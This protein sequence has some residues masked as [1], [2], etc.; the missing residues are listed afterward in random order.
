MTPRALVIG[1]LGTAAA[2]L[3]IAVGVSR[4]Q[5][6]FNMGGGTFAAPVTS[7]RDMPFRQVV[8]QQYDYSC[9]SAALATLLRHHYGRNVTEASI[10]Q[11]MFAVGDQDKIRRVG[12]SLLDMK[13]HLAALGLKSDGYR[14]TL[15]DLALAKAPAIA[16]IKVGDYRHFVVIKGVRDGKVMVGDPNQGLKLY[17]LAEFGRVWNGVVFVIHPDGGQPAF[18][19]RDEWASLAYGPMDRLDD[20]SLAAF[21]RA[22]PPI[23]QVMASRETGVSR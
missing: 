1:L 11:A 17:S 18:N 19:R 14:Q 23:Y 22:L 10:F 6:M 16:L 4:A 21:T 12:F 2:S 20:R 5:P 8:R 9:G 15:Q 7:L 3:S 13:T